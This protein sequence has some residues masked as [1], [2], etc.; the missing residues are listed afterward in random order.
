MPIDLHQLNFETVCEKNRERTVKEV[1]PVREENRGRTVKEVK[2]IREENRE[3]TVKE[4]KK[5]VKNRTQ[6]SYEENIKVFYKKK[7]TYREFK[8]RHFAIVFSD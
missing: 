5:I 3:S 1:K 4:V 7:I 8:Q 2:P 6:K